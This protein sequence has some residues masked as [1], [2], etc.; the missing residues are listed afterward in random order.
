[1]EITRR[2]FLYAVA[3]GAFVGLGGC[4]GESDSPKE[5]LDVNQQ[6][7][8]TLEDH[9]GVNESSGREDLAKI[10]FEKGHDSSFMVDIPEIAAFENLYGEKVTLGT[11]QLGWPVYEGERKLRIFEY[12]RN[13]TWSGEVDFDNKK[14]QIL[15]PQ[16]LVDAYLEDEAIL[17]DFIDGFVGDTNAPFSFAINAAPLSQEIN[18]GGMKISY[19]D[20]YPTGVTF[21]GGVD[22]PFYGTLINLNMCH[23]QSERLGLSVGQMLRELMVN[24]GV[25]LTA[26]VEADRRGEPLPQNE[27]A[28]TLGGFAAAFN[29]KWD[30]FFGGN[31]F[32]LMVDRLAQDMAN[33]K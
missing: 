3:G 25:N 5:H 13:N 1:M 11:N 24:E 4:G 16:V 21:R 29:P 33:L 7:V 17:S 23:I 30:R 26:M 31:S 28:S 14:V 10:A 15:G 6:F 32:T 12:K 22:N 8:K 20:N 18:V 27:A 2:H 19:P 9:L